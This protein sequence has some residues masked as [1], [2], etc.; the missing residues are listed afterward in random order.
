MAREHFLA[1]RGGLPKHADAG[2]HVEAKD[3]PDQPELR[4]F[5]RIIDKD[6]A[7]GDQ[8]RCLHRR[9]V[10]F[11][12]PARRRHPHDE[13]ADHHEDEVDRSQDDK[14][15]GDA[16]VVC[17]PE[18]AHQPHRKRGGDEG[19]AAEAHDGHAGRHARP[20]GEPF[21]QGRDRRDVADAEPAAAKHAITEIDDPEIVDIG[22]DRGNEE[23]ARPA[24]RGGEHR[25]ARAAFLD[26]AAENRRGEAKEEDRKGEDPAEFGEIPIA[27]R[28]LQMPMSLVIGRLKTLKA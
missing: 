20:V 22:A 26:P 21:D 25:P 9:G 19:A 17:R 10:A 14:C 11:R 8:L 18:Y 7:R 2:G 24:Q 27:R 3:P 13:R 6:V 28:R 1:H 12:L 16:D 23:A 4:R 5:Q 15:G